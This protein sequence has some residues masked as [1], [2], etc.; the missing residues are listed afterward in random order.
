MEFK[1][2]KDKPLWFKF[3]WVIVV[4][5]LFLFGMFF[6]FLIDLWAA[7]QTIFYFCVG[8]ECGDC[9]FYKLDHTCVNK[10]N[11]KI[12]KYRCAHYQGG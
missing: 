3:L 10:P 11:G 6:I 1:D 9:M 2:G 4:G 8:I 7:I 12:V 5:I